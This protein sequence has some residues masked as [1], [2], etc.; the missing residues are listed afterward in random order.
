MLLGG[1][2]YVEAFREGLRELG[3]V[4]G[5]NV[6]IEYGYTEGKRDRY[7]EFLAELVRLKVDVIIADGS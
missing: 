6:I 4:E 1:S 3:Y 7:Y 2:P 5:K